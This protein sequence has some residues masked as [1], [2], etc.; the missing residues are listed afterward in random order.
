MV[1]E[2]FHR[3]RRLRDG[4][5]EQKRIFATLDLL[6]NPTPSSKRRIY[7]PITNS[8]LIYTS[9]QFLPALPD[10]KL[11]APYAPLALLSRLRTFQPSTYAPSHP[12]ALS[13]PTV[14]LNGWLNEGHE[15]LKCGRCSADCSLAGLAEIRDEKVRAE[16]GRRVGAAMTERHAKGC[17]WRVR[18]S[19][20]Q[21]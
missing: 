16:V 15:R 14:S 5:S 2:R 1:L 6:L 20:G 11:Y 18:N 9:S 4:L 8:P 10:P 12:P 21:S 7:P 3:R 17:A 19:P 13:P